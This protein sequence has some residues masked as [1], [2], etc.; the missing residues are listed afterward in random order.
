MSERVLVIGA[1]MA[2]L[3]AALALAA[4]GRRIEVLE[5]D[6]PAPDGGADE[7]FADWNRRGVGHLR[8][9]HAFLARLRAVIARTHPALLEDFKAAGIQ[10]LN[11]V[12]GLNPHARARYR[13]EPE[14]DGLTVLTS[15]RTTLE[16]VMRRYV[17]R[18]PGVRIRAG[19][20][21]VGLTGAKDDQGRYVCA[22]LQIE[23]AEGRRAETA[24]VVVDGAGR[25]SQ[26][27][28]WLAEAGVET[29]EEAEDA[30]ILYFT[31][32]WRLLP[33]QAEPP[34]GKVPGAG[35]MGY[36]KYG[37]FPGDNGCFSVTL[38]VPEIEETLRAA[39]L[40]PEVFDRICALLPGLS[41]WTD[42]ARATPISKVY[43]M[44]DLKSRWRSTV[45]DGRPQALNLFFLGDGLIRTNPLYGRGCTFAAIE[46]EALAEALKAPDPA[47]RALAYQA[48]VDRE[49]RPFYLFMRG[50]D[51]Q[52]IRRARHTLDGAYR[53]GLKARLAKSFA[54]DC[55]APA[56]RADPALLREFMRGFHMLELADVWLKR[57]ANRLKLL[58]MWATPRPL[59]ARHYPPRLGPE[60]R[61]LFEALGLDPRADAARLELVPA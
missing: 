47:A 22:G 29:P 35:D 26:G 43:G 11:F 45:R 16:L 57:P 10:E 30:G 49:L 53:P 58:A 7:A 39:V 5:R 15:R 23:D 55:L 8:H 14:D 61:E 21:V 51:R 25:L 27:F 31:R 54:S 48:A 38:S 32:H 37:V 13:P 60:R 9:S 52:A 42:P 24:D 33:G 3:F 19:V 17:E 41:R 4:P 2:G 20:N 44:G 6:P 50:Q 56:L 18:L 59:K 34:R 12:D 1:G 36:I 46:A 40:R 28:D